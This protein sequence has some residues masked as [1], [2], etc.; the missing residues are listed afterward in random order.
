MEKFKNY[1]LQKIEKS[2]HS[3]FKSICAKRGI[4]M[5]KALLN[6]MKNFTR[7]GDQ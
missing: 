1:H 6:F 2:L 4:S 3:D 7:E 5:R